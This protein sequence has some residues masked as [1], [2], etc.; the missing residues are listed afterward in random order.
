MAQIDEI[1]DPA[2]ELSGDIEAAIEQQQRG[3]EPEPV[4]EAP[5][6]VVEETSAAPERDEK[7][8]FKPRSEAPEAEAAPEKVTEPKEAEPAPE[9]GAVAQKPPPGFS[10]ASKAEWEKLPQHVRDDIAKREAEVDNGFKR[11]AGLGRFAEEAERN[12]RTL[13]DAVT[14]YVNVESILRRDPVAGV[15]FL[16][17]KMNFNPRALAWAM[18]QRYGANGQDAQPTQNPG[19]QYTPPVDPRAIAEYAA[20][21]VRTE[22]QQ[23]QIDSDIVAFGADPKNKFFHNLRPVMA[24]IVQ[25]GLATNLQQAYDAACWNHPETRAILINEANG[26]ANKQASATASRAR[27]AAKAI[28]GSPA[29][30][31]NPDA[32]GKRQKQSIDDDIDAAIAAQEG[33]A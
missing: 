23:K 20:N 7:G 16:C 19:P 1:P 22:F 13:Q 8:R 12:G 14:D 30:G 27:N 17:Q 33:A 3:G 15:E 18:S 5:E 6:S 11:Y 24:Q 26:G 29:E 31:I 21:V 32:K 2:D 9:L 4:E 10:V 25:A 28:G